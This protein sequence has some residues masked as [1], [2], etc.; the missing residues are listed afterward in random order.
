MLENT[1]G[2]PRESRFDLPPTFILDSIAPGFSPGFSIGSYPAL[3]A[4]SGQTSPWMGP[5]QPRAVPQEIRFAF[6]NG[7]KALSAPEWYPR[8]KPGAIDWFLPC[9]LTCYDTPG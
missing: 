8:L 7:A 2:F 3:A 5:L 6:Q 4:R 9:C 1:L